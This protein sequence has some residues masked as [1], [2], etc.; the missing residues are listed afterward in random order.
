MLKNIIKI[1]Y[2]SV[3][4]TI[5]V[6]RH[7]KY[8]RFYHLSLTIFKAAIIFS[9]SSGEILLRGRNLILI[10]NKSFHHQK[11]KIFFLSVADVEEC[12][13]RGTVMSSQYTSNDDV[14]MA[15]DLHVEI[16]WM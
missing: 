14:S 10:C 5:L 8:F 3:T 12:E 11:K 2:F 6:V 9:E 4:L 16:L 7:R 15:Y 13:S 1:K